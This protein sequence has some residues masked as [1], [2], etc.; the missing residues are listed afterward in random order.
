MH[1]N[2]DVILGISNIDSIEFKD[3][4]TLEIG[5]TAMSFK[6]NKPAS[7]IGFKF[8]GDVLVLVDDQSGF[9]AVDDKL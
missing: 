5:S 2:V 1:G 9:G 6:A 7:D 8:M 3:F 4:K